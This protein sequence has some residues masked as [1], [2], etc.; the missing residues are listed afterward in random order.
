MATPTRIPSIRRGLVAAGVCTTVAISAAVG[1]LGAGDEKTVNF[2]GYPPRAAAVNAGNINATTPDGGGP[3][4]F[5][6]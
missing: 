4:V 3:D 5:A 6:V 2:E 1:C